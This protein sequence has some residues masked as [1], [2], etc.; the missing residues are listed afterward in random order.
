MDAK[1][2]VSK[3]KGRAYNLGFKLGE[4]ADTLGIKR[5]TMSLYVTGRV[6]PPLGVYITVENKLKQLEESD[7]RENM[8]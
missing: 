3:W 1:K 6:T 8:V 7:G 2:Q 4:F 5:H